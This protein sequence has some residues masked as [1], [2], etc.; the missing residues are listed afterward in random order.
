MS[1]DSMVIVPD[2]FAPESVVPESVAVDLLVEQQDTVAPESES[3][4]I[5]PDSVAPESE[6]APDSLPPGAFVCG[7]CGLVHE[8]REAWDRAHSVF[9]P[10]SRCGLVHFEWM[11]LA[12]F[13]GFKEFDCKVFMPDLDKV[14]RHGD[15]VVF[16]ANVL[17]MLRDTID[18]RELAAAGKDDD[19]K[20]TVR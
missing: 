5:V 18:E 17:Q 16:D 7:R 20:A 14:Q 15:K 3:I 6:H 8:N 10:C 9:W 12:M 19:T 11:L 2:S 4:E 13:Y 1:P